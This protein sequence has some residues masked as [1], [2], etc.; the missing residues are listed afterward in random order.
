MK[1]T[2]VPSSSRPDDVTVR[3]RVLLNAAVNRPFTPDEIAQ[4]ERATTKAM[5]ALRMVCANLP[6]L[7]GLASLARV[8]PDSRVMV[9]AVTSA[10]RVVI[11]PRVFDELPLRDATFVMAHEL[12]HVALDTFGREGDL[13]P[14][15]ANIAHD[16]VINDMLRDELGMEIP[17]GALDF[18]GARDM[19]FEQVV[20]RLHSDPNHDPQRT[21]C[22][23]VAGV[24]GHGPLASALQNAGLLP[25]GIPADDILDGED[26]IPDDLAAELFPEDVGTRDASAAAARNEQLR[27]EAAKCVSLRHMQRDWDKFKKQT[28][29]PGTEAGNV[30]SMVEALRRAYRT[31]WELALQRW[32]EA[33]VQG[34]RTYARPSRRGADR[35]DC[36]LPGRSREGWTLHVVLDTSGSMV[37]DLPKVLGALASFCETA[38]VSD[39][40]LLQC[41]T[42]VTTDE[43]VPVESLDNYQV[44]GFGGS[45]MSPAMF[46]LADDPEVTAVVVLTDGYIEYPAAE[47]PYRVLWI[48]VTNSES[49]CIHTF[50]YGDAIRL[51]T[52][53]L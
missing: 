37:S 36:V 20:T 25:D 16:Y 6:W 1:R 38:G 29:P 48:V 40:H 3:R 32:I 43:W 52:A 28:P 21:R 53:D 30:Y 35:T 2:R 5:Q 11:N 31:P 23:T 10:A 22:W 19:S 17:L 9:A 47:P 33:N 44:H 27:R 8:S 26:M 34:Q 39:V 13:K 12:L 7:S 18:Q 24:G 42:V 45:D 4:R 41:D 14:R 15:V 51:A 50:P 49:D 46:K